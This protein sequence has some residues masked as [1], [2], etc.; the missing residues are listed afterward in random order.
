MSVPRLSPSTA[1]TLLSE[2]PAHA[3]AFSSQL[4]KLKKKSTKALDKGALIDALILPGGPVIRVIDF[5]DF[6]KD[7][8]Q[9][10]REKA[11]AAG[12]LPVLRE[13]YEEALAV[14]DILVKKMGEKDVY[15]TGESH[16]KSEWA[17]PDTGVL[18][19]GEMDHVILWPKLA[20]VYD[21]KTAASANPE[22]FARSAVSFAYD[23]QEAAYTEAIEVRV[24]KLAG[25]V[26]FTFVVCET[27]PPYAVT[28]IR[29]D[30]QFRAMGRAKWG[31]ACRR[32]KECLDSGKWPDYTNGKER[33]TVSPK[34]WQLTEALTL[35]G[36]EEIAL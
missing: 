20:E 7:A 4:G 19:R 24:P 14:A 34:P 35:E 6:K 12:E 31:A 15:L 11:E 10:E 33:A 3:Y 13:K 5:K 22:A 36:V 30:G 1:K 26:L 9:A 28:P 18:C 2:S 29:L 17:N 27:E 23:V 32:W 25:K 21:I 8:A 16:Y